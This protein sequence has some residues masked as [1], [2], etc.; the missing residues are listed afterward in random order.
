M[1]RDRDSAE[2]R[3]LSVKPRVGADGERVPMASGVSGRVV[4]VSGCSS[5]IGKSVCEQLAVAGARTYGGSRT[6]CA[7]RGWRYL[8]LDVTDRASVQDMVDEVVRREGR[9]DAV[10][11]CAGFGLAGPLE[12]MTDEHALRQFDVNF[13]GTTRIVQCALPVMR[14]QRWGRIIAI[15]SIAGL[16]GLP[17]VAHYCAAKFALD[18]MIEALRAEIRPFGIQATIVHPGDFSTSFGANRVFVGDDDV[19][20]AYADASRR[21]LAYYRFQEDNAPAPDAVARRVVR[22]MKRRSLP[23]RV[24]VGSPLEKLGVIGKRILDGR[25]FEFAL[26][27]AYGPG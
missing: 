2:E 8:R 3:G 9:L 22:L 13:F 20:H 24:V 25:S 18:G 7:P 17:F 12:T 10:V 26:R 11:T 5:G 6:E 4:L 23:V 16:I 21:A 15:G 19:A 27:K 14:A 1:A